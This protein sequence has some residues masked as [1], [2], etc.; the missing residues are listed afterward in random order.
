MEGLDVWMLQPG[1]RY[2]RHDRDSWPMSP[3]QPFNIWTKS[4]E[5]QLATEAMAASPLNYDH[6]D[7][8]NDVSNG[9]L[10]STSAAHER[11]SIVPA[12]QYRPSREQ[13]QVSQR[14][15]LV[16]HAL[17]SDFEE[18]SSPYGLGGS[19]GA[20]DDQVDDADKNLLPS[21]GHSLTTVEI[22]E[23]AITKTASLDG[24]TS[25][26]VL[27]SEKSTASFDSVFGPSS[28]QGCLAEE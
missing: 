5:D 13:S 19:D 23:P 16:D 15:A 7:K 6:D 3:G 9:H 18:S 10:D 27:P 22:S 25:D 21:T 20:C 28:S 12:S 8:E 14:I 11:V 24:R 1:D 26:T 4:L 2:F 17:Y